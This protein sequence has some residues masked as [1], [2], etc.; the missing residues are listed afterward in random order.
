MYIKPKKNKI[1]I[2][3]KNT[4]N[5]QTKFPNRRKICRRTHDDPVLGS[6]YY[7]EKVRPI[8]VGDLTLC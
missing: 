2:I 5:M 8:E 4:M 6:T 3:L 7:R 1:K